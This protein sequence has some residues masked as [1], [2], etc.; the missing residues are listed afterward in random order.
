MSPT[1][2]EGNRYLN[3]LAPTPLVQVRLG[4][5]EPEV[6]CKLELLNPSGSTKDRVARFILEK[7][8]RQGRLGPN[9]RVIEASSGST[10]I[11]LALAC[12]QMGLRFLAVMPEGVSGERVLIIRAYG[13]Q[14]RLTPKAEGIR[15]AL[16]AV[17]RLGR[18]PGTFLPRQF[19]NPDNAEAHRLGTAR[20]MVDQL[21][22]GCADGVV[23]G[24]G[25]G[26]TLMG[27][28]QG[29]REH[30]CPVRPFLA[31]PVNLTTTPEAECCSFSARIPGVA[32]QLST[33]FQPASLPGL[34]VLEINDELALETTRQLMAL[35]F[36]VGP[37]SG[38]N[39]QAALLARQRLGGDARVVTVFPDRME[40]YFTTEVFRPFAPET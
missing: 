28:F 12:A 10:S 35:G 8:W 17:E 15:G 13:G 19:A 34:E 5:G 36:P 40:R 24:V 14:V 1:L 20:E 22:G 39:Y 11:A 6:W 9:D 23:S 16:A 38:L 3:R 37:S 7:A 29:L 18:E 26:G 33:I 30:G 31:R 2:P 25:T 32:D 27:L 21:P 4:P